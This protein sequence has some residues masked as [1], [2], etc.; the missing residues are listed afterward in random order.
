VQDLV[1]VRVADP[2]DVRLRAQHAL[3]L[4]TALRLQ[5]AVEHLDGEGRVERVGPQP[6]DARHLVGG[7]HHPDR[8]RLLR[9]VLGEVEARAVI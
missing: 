2:G 9:A 3:D 7:A 4:G 8:E 1:G 6:R 5:D